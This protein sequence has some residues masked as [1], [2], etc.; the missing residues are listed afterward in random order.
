MNI[1][2]TKLP[3]NLQRL[4]KCVGFEKAEEFISIYGGRSIRIPTG[5]QSRMVK[6]FGDNYDKFVEEFSAGSFV[7]FPTSAKLQQQIRDTNII[8]DINEGMSKEF[9]M[10]KYGISKSLVVYI[11]RG[12]DAK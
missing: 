7:S 2:V 1:D 10:A 8:H 5:R 11:L 9:V 4:V 12:R 6:L 3:K